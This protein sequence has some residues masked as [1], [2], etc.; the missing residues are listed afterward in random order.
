V[1]R[2]IGRDTDVARVL[3]WLGRENDNFR[4]VLRRALRRQDAASALRMG[5]ALVSFWYVSG[6]CAEGGGWMEQVAGLASAKPYERAV[7]QTIAAI[8]AFFQGDFEPLETGLDDAIGVIGDGRDRRIVAFAQ[9]LQA[10]A[11]GAGSREGRWQDAVTEASGRL[12]SEGDPLAVGVGLAAA[13]LLARTNGRMEEARRLAQQAHDLSAQMGESYVHMSASSQLA[14]AFL[15]LGDVAAARSSAIETLQVARRLRNMSAMG[16]ALELGRRPSSGTAEIERAGHLY[17][18]SS[19]PVGYRV[20]PTDA[21]EHRKLD[22]ELRAALG[23]RYKLMFAQAHTVDLDR[24]VDELLESDPAA[25][26]YAVNDDLGSM[27]RLEEFDGIASWIVHYHLLAAPTL[28]DVWLLAY[29]L[30]SFT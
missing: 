25:T 28:N 5:R 24:A 9:L 22:T 8:E 18:D 10:M 12:Q 16:Y 15:G 6:S 3:D 7:A 23:E 2:L 20:W 26:R 27:L 19:W 21:E 17:A 4:A 30:P 29:P 11:Q 14:R 1:T 13:A